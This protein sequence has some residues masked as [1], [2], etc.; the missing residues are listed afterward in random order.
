MAE[1][2]IT[3]STGEDD[4]LN[5]SNREALL[6]FFSVDSN[7]NMACNISTSS[8]PTYNFYSK[9]FVLKITQ[10][11]TGIICVAF[12]TKGVTISAETLPYVCFPHVVFGS[13]III[14]S[15][16]IMSYIFG[17]IMPDV[18]TRAFL[19]IGMILYFISATISITVWSSKKSLTPDMDIPQALLL[20][21]AILSYANSLLYGLDLF[22]NIKKAVNFEV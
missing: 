12:Y 17:Q 9:D 7:I 11:A 14:T 6:R 13:Y 3:Q 18:V 19:S 1:V 15:V 2:T 4:Q 10:L 22:F 16:I 5:R 20:A 21:Q 8:P